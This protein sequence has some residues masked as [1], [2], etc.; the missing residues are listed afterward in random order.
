MFSYELDSVFLLIENV[1]IRLSVI[2]CMWQIFSYLISVMY[3]GL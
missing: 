1:F 3:S 2:L